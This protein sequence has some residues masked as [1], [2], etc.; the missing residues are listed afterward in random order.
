MINGQQKL[1]AL[2]HCALG[3][4]EILGRGF[5]SYQRISSHVTQA[6][7]SLSKAVCG[8]ADEAAAFVGTRFARMREEFVSLR[9]CERNHPGPRKRGVALPPDVRKGFAFPFRDD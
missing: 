8:A 3:L 7:D 4:E 2:A 6:I 1:A 5:I 9:L